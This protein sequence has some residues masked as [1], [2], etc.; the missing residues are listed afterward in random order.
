MAG[1]VLGICNLPLSKTKTLVL[2]EH[3]SQKDLVN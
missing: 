1:I 2:M 3:M